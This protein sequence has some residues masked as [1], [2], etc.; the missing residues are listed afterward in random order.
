MLGK[1]FVLLIIL[2]SLFELQAQDEDNQLWLNY[3]MSAPLNEKWTVGGDAGVRGLVSNSEWNQVLIRPSVTYTLSKRSKL[4]GAIGLFST[5]NKADSLDVTE[6][7]LHQQFK[8]NGPDFR[9]FLTFWRVRVEERFFFYR[10]R[11][12]RFSWR[13]RLLGGLQTLD[14][15]FFGKR[16]LPSYFQFTIEGFLNL[17][18]TNFEELFVNNFRTDFAFGQRLSNKWRYELHYIRQSSRLGSQDGFRVAQNV[19]RLRVFYKIP[20]KKQEPPED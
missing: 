17:T 16:G 9:W 18:N 14:F 2:F 5:F 7:R 4:A 8:F 12:D 6:L 15:N 19:F 13:G 20:L 1:R 11:P 10:D 3:S